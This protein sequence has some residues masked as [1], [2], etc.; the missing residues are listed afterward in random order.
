[1][2][3]LLARFETILL[4]FAS[5][6]SPCLLTDTGF[7]DLSSYTSRFTAA[8][9][10]SNAF[11]KSTRDMLEIS[12]G[13]AGHSLNSLSPLSHI[14]HLII[15]AICLIAVESLNTFGRED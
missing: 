11:K 4:Q 9:L 14:L 8:R 1:M 7:Q 10:D 2:R 12:S 15:I 6:F 3:G 13:R 5:Q